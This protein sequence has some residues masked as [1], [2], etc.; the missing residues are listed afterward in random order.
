[1]ASTKTVYICQECGAS[2]AKWIGKCPSC[3]S[4]NSYVE[5][6]VSSGQSKNSSGKIIRTL[7]SNKPQKISEIQS[8]DVVR[9]DTENNEFNRVLGGGIVRLF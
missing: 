3:G 1:M 7:S 8:N 2:S 5:E 4:W 9:I 6:I